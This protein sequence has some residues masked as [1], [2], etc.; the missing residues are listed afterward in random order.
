MTDK[1]YAIRIYCLVFHVEDDNGDTD[2]DGVLDIIASLPE[3]ERIALESRYRYDKKYREIA[4]EIGGLHPSYA[5]HIV[6]KARVKLR[7]TIRRRKMSASSMECIRVN[8]A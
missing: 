8:G 6:E 7:H 3:R 1:E 5:R 2:I 4:I